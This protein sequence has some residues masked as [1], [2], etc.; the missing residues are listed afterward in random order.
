MTIRIIAILIFLAVQASQLYFI[1]FLQNWTPLGIDTGIPDSVTVALLQN[2][3]LLLLFGAVHSVMA[4]P[5]VKRRL[6]G[7]LPH[8]LER[9]VY[10]LVAA[11]QLTTIVAFWA[12]IPAPLWTVS[13]QAGICA[14][15]TLF[16]AGNLMLLWG[17][18]CI[19]SLHFFG[20]RQAFYGEAAEPAFSMRGPYRYVRHPIQTGLIMT[21]WATPVMTQGHALLAGFLTLYS[22]AA[23]LFLEEKD[24]ESALGDSYASYRNKV[25]ALLPFPIRRRS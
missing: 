7:A 6:Y 9:S 13:S 23:T 15:Y 5:A 8:R 20:L 11:A 24:L 21:L 19:D 16:I 18:H 12:P 17:I 3:A 14:A 4:R 10:T 22:V 1:G 25:P 2:I